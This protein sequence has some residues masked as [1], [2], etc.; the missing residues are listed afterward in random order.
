MEKY[1][2]FT[3]I[4]GDD[5]HI[6]IDIPSIEIPED[7]R[8]EGIISNSKE[9][10]DFYGISNI[11]KLGLN[12]YD[13]AFVFRRLRSTQYITPSPHAYGIAV[14]FFSVLNALNSTKKDA[15]FSRA[16]YTAFI[17]ILEKWGW[18][19]IGRYQDF[20]FMHFQAAHYGI[21]QASTY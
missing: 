9:V 11:E 1:D 3:E 5:I 2:V 15:L 10:L 16:P 4:V 7:I 8:I 18:Y 12:R 21:K 20:D 17:D 6:A 14:D 19:S 13:G